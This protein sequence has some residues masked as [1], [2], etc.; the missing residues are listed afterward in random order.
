MTVAAKVVV[1]EAGAANPFPADAFRRRGYSDITIHDL[2]EAPLD[3]NGTRP[4]IVIV[5]AGSQAPAALEA[6]LRGG[7][8]QESDSPLILITDE[9][10][11]EANSKPDEHGVGDAFTQVLSN[12]LYESQ[13]FSRVGSLVRLNAMRAEMRRRAASAEEFG[14]MLASVVA[15]PQG[16]DRARVLVAAPPGTEVESVR[17]GLADFSISFAP[18]VNAVPDLL[19][20]GGYDALVLA[21][22]EDVS[23]L[24]TLADLRCNS[25][26][27]H[28]PVI[29]IADP[30]C[31]SESSETELHA[32]DDVLM[33]PLGGRDLRAR[34]RALVLQHR[35]RS[36]MTGAYANSRHP[37]ITDGLTG[38]YSFGFLHTHLA[39]QIAEAERAGKPLTVCLF[40]I[41]DLKSINQVQG[42][43]A[44]DALLR[45][46]A[47]VV[48]RLVRGEDLAARYGADR[49]CVVLPDTDAEYA[50]TVLQR[51][52][53]VISN[54]EFAIRD[55]ADAVH[56][57]MKSALAQ[58]NR[59]ET[60]E[61]LIERA[62]ASA[63][64]RLVFADGRVIVIDEKLT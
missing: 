43:A 35:Y 60:A 13:L 7:P 53:S 51:I 10:I 28:F 36:E 11:G 55:G 20:D 64:I 61:A 16:T 57:V 14:V 3:T 12:P 59:G 39:R 45:Q 18:N 21:I 40:D 50:E 1:Y 22:D 52:L 33:R 46:V 27:Y 58:R 19:V 15:V 38:L 9:L 5:N 30:A 41:K 63:N 42:Y 54:T 17:D 32:A 24:Q 25:R 34:L 31:L 2:G 62:A 26:L 37:S 23:P 56:L 49:F 29:V 4:D 47:G 48:G 44:G 6:R 8:N